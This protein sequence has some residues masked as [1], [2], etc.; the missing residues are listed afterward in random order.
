MGL[1]LTG[2]SYAMEE[3]GVFK[4]SDKGGLPQ[5]EIAQ[6]SEQKISFE[7]VK[8]VS[9]NTCLKCHTGG[10]HSMNTPEKVLGNQDRIIEAID[11]GT[12]PPPA[13]GYKAMTSC[14]AKILET[15]LEDQSNQRPEAEILKVKDLPACGGLEAPKEKP[16]TDYKNLELSFENL[17]KEILAPKC[18]TCHSGP[19]PSD[20]KKKTNLESLPAL[21]EQELINATAEESL[22]YQ[23]VVGIDLPDGKRKQMPP[24][25]SGIPTLSAEQLDY[26]KRW[27]D[28]GAR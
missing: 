14:E 19:P 13:S 18:L 21:H 1:T 7:V 5:I 2:C 22:L 9:L 28:A 20:G 10:D 4:T 6:F 12:M 15:W 8:A 26:V 16:A 27:I 11:L 24:A 3:L 25:K 17:T 23:I